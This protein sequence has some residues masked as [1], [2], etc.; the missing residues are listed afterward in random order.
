RKILGIETTESLT[1]TKAKTGKLTVS[2][3]D[4]KRFLNRVAQARTP[5]LFGMRYLGNANGYRA[6]RAGVVMKS[7]LLPSGLAMS[8]HDFLANALTKDNQLNEDAKDY[9]VLWQLVPQQPG[10]PAIGTYELQ[11]VNEHEGKE[12]VI[13]VGE[14]KM[15]D[16][17]AENE[18]S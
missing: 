10:M 11:A 6:R 15:M 3:A 17:G 7:L 1:P 14:V 2:F 8:E 5:Y 13:S 9:N 18:S 12:V 4:Q 16:A